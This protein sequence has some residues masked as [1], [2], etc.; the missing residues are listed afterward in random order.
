MGELGEKLRQAREAKGVSLAEI[1]AQTRIGVRMLQA[2]ETEQFNHLPGGVF[3]RSFL[4]QYAAFLDLE[5]ENFVQDYLRRLEP[6]REVPDEP[7]AP[8]T[9]PVSVA[10][11]QALRWTLGSAGLALLVVGI[12]FFSLRD[13]SSNETLEL[14]ATPEIAESHEAASA[15]TPS[16][17]ASEI[18]K[19]TEASSA[20]PGESI[21]TV[22]GP[23]ASDPADSAEPEP[24]A[25]PARPSAAIFP[26]VDP[27][28]GE[29]LVLQ[30]N[31]HST[32][33]LAI[34]ADGEKLWQGTLQPDQSREVEAS[35]SIRVTVG[36][37][38]GVEMTLNGESLGALGQEGE[39][40]TITLAA[41]GT[42]D[43]V[44]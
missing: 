9:L 35:D 11:S 2:L 19:L 37:A 27:E 25:T 16:A 44:F 14:A 40:K 21:S 23:S 17:A 15:P 29:V 26:A 18:G 42:S 34:T 6:P 22:K 5:Q 13:R 1:A 32:V 12:L 24:A 28:G 33:W 31:A 8:T 3:N 7:S 39:V 36:N 4:R 43:P 38:G 30:I 10:G 41:G 20:L